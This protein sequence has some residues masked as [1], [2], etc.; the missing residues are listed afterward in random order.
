MSAGIGA[1]FLGGPA[2]PIQS[3]GTTSVKPIGSKR[4]ARAA[5][6]T[7]RVQQ[8]VPRP[9]GKPR[10]GWNRMENSGDGPVRGQAR[11]VQAW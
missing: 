5:G 3:C 1:G 2:R 9:K 10:E 7:L 8:R 4:E 6:Q 11:N